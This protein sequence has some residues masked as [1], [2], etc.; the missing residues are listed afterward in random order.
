MLRRRLRG[1]DSAHL[2]RIAPV[3]P[4][5]V[6]LLVGGCGGAATSG[7]AGSARTP[8][9]SAPSGASSPSTTPRALPVSD[10]RSSF[11]VT[12][13]PVSSSVIVTA[14][15]FLWS[16]APGQDF[17]VDNLTVTNPTS[18]PETLSDF[19]NLTS[20]LAANLDFVMSAAN[21]GA[22]GFSSDCEVHAGFPPGLCPISFAEGLT[23]DSNSVVRSSTATNTLAPGASAQIMVSYGP[24]S[25]N[26][27][28]DAV[29]VYFH[30]GV[31]AP[32]GL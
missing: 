14:N 28:P 20:G 27:A 18:N 25:A 21:A 2:T 13:S 26:V 22:S 24:V 7:S 19:D 31:S 17:L 4:V 11:V 9:T 3:C 16:A 32:V 30:N 12:A 10:G 8:P 1:H 6:A 5:A 23:V 15:S 29:S